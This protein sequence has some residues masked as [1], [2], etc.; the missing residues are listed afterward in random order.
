MKE[1]D[2]I[3]F[4]C[5]KH[6]KETYFNIKRQEA[7]V[8]DEFV[9]V[10]FRMKGQNEKMW[11]KITEGDRREGVG[12]LNNVPVLVG[13]DFGDIVKFKTNEEGITYGH[14]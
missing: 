13:L 3:I 11:V 8:P 10:W 9:Y 5:T 2:N 14:K 4:T 1:K 7:L 12:K 6:G